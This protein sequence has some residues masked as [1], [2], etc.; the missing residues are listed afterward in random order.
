MGHQIRFFLCTAMRTAIE[1]E[2]NRLG[3]MLVMDYS[4]NISAIHFS[5]SAGTDQCQGR[6]WTEAPDLTHYKALCRVV[7]KDANYD[8][9]SGLWV[10]RTSRMAFDTYRE[11][12]KKALAEL[13]ERNRKYAIEVLGGHVTNEKG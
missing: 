11:A 12:E 13:V 3:A 5:D 10:K 7:K 1:T 6:L 2:A 9:E 4:T 8:Q